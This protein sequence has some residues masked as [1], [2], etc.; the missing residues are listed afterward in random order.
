MPTV[1]SQ[2]ARLQPAC[3]QATTAICPLIQPT[4]FS[5]APVITA[6]PTPAVVNQPT[7]FQSAVPPIVLPVLPVSHQLTLQHTGSQPT[8]LRQTVES[9]SVMLQSAIQ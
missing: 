7:V 6:R 9:N 5:N 1:A 8:T 3:L 2:S 4:T